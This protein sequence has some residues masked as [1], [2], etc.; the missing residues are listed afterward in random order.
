MIMFGVMLIFA[1]LLLKIEH[2]EQDDKRSF[3]SISDT[4]YES[5]GLL[6]GNSEYQYNNSYKRAYLLSAFITL[7]IIMSNLVI[8]VISDIYEQV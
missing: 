7:Q 2:L 3:L 1:I 8:S 6:M 5:I 4:F